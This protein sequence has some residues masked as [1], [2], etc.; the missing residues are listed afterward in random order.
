MVVPSG[1]GPVLWRFVADDRLCAGCIPL[2]PSIVSSASSDP[3]RGEDQARRKKQIFL[4]NWVTRLHDFLN[5]NER[6]VL[7]DAGKVSRE[8]ARQFAETEYERFA[9]RRRE[10]LEAQGESD[11]LKLLDAEVKKLPKKRKP[12]KK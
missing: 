1:S 9:T 12:P 7:P 3:P 5:L 6:A 2:R 4:P 11:L 10:A 8:E